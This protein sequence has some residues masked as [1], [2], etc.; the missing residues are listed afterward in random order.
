MS[1]TDLPQPG[2]PLNCS[3]QRKDK[4]A[5]KIECALTETG[6]ANLLYKMVERDPCL[7]DI[8]PLYQSWKLLKEP[9]LKRI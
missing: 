9:S 8:C 1:E 6:Q 3:F 7:I 4:G 2:E 5:K